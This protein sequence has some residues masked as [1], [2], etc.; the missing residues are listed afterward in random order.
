MNR[1]RRH[2]MYFFLPPPAE[3]RREIAQ[4]C[5]PTLVGTPVR[6][7]RLHVTIGTAGGYDETP[8]GVIALIVEALAD[9]TLPSCGLVFDTVIG[10]PRS[11]LLKPS[12]RLRGFDTLQIRIATAIGLHPALWSHFRPH[13]TLGYNGRPM[14]ARSIDPISWTADRLCLVESLHGET[15]HIV[16]GSWPLTACTQKAA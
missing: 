16:H 2:H 3:I 7:D 4:W 9:L 10:G 15:R 5:S 14:P 11:A 1:Q 6:E 12:E 13:I 8:R